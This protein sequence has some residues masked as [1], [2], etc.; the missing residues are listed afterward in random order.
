MR[1]MISSPIT[2]AR[3]II[4]KVTLLDLA[5]STGRPSR[6]RFVASMV[7]LCSNCRWPIATSHGS[8]RVVWRKRSTA[9]TVH[10]QCVGFVLRN[11]HESFS[12]EGDSGHELV[13]ADQ[14]FQRQSACD[15][16][17]C[18]AARAGMVAGRRGWSIDRSWIEAASQ[19]S[20]AAQVVADR[21]E[22]LKAQF[23]A[24][25]LFGRSAA[26]A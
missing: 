19:D 25:L 7:H 11:V 1:W 12:S 9:A 23:K 18:R 3:S 8:R 24:R 20:G 5:A 6:I 15:R 17:L 16:S 4:R 10:P 26:R 22:A 21:P 14:P 2:A 13:S